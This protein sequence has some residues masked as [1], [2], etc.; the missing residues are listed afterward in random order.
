MSIETIFTVKNEDLRDLNPKYHQHEKGCTQ[1][2]LCIVKC[3]SS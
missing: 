2:T 3:H 1:G